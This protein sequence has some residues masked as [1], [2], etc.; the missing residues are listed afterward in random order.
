MKIKQFTKPYE[1]PSCE[2]MTLLGMSVICTSGSFGSST[3]T[4][5]DFTEFNS[6]DWAL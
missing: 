2:D 6:S 3:E 1:A 5:Q 4:L